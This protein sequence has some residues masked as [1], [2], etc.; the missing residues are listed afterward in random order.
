MSMR[1]FLSIL[2][3]TT[4]AFSGLI[5]TASA[6]GAKEIK[7]P[8]LL[9]RL[10]AELKKLDSAVADERLKAARALGKLCDGRAIN[11]LL[12]HLD[13]EDERVRIA[14]VRALGKI[15]DPE[16]IPRLTECLDRDEVPL[17]LAVIDAFLNIESP[18]AVPVL[19]VLIRHEDE[20]VRYNA[21]DAMAA[22]PDPSATTII[23]GF[24]KTASPKEKVKAAA[25]LGSLD[26]I[27][28]VPVLIDMLEDNASGVRA[29]SARALKRITCIRHGF[30]ANADEEKRKEAVKSLRKWWKK[31]EPLG[32][33][34]WLIDGLNDW[35]DRTR[36]SCARGL[37][38]HGTKKAI[39]ALMGALGDRLSGVRESASAAL[40]CI[41]GLD[42]G[43][44][45]SAKKEER[46]KQIALWKKWWRKNSASDKR[47]WMIDALKE[48]IPD[49]RRRAAG[50]LVKYR[51]AE[52]ASA[53][54]GA[55]EDGMAG[56]RAAA[57]LSLR[58]ITKAHFGFDP[59][60]TEVERRKAV[61][62]WREFLKRWR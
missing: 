48:E 25:V 7:D 11:P 41:V 21:L 55:L 4:V 1:F 9:E 32:R 26:D 42:F 8:K 51:D 46:K 57:I 2:V 24:L 38:R 27:R 5:N 61:I 15:G 56:V 62:N 22:L 44:E 45:P 59:N 36:A 50:A 47:G 19:I 54:A 31:S 60:G 35:E 52:V 18:K 37:F 13:D 43:Y 17:T 14:A 53:L 3:L 33:E 30:D 16:V 34:G 39:P 6:A 40:V 28:A 10:E 20:K 12:A 29:A 58:K 23:L 49:N